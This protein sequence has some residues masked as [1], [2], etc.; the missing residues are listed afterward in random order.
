[1]L[2]GWHRFVVLRGRGRG[3]RRGIVIVVRV[4]VVGRRGWR[5]WRGARHGVK[6]KCCKCENNTRQRED[7]EMSDWRVTDVGRIAKN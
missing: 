5:G 3:R 4:V 1:M 2:D 7:R 6:D